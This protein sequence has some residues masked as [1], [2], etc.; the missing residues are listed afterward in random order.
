MYLVIYLLSETRF[1]RPGRLQNDCVA[2]GTFE[3]LSLLPPLKCWNY[4][5]VPPCPEHVLTLREFPALGRKVAGLGR[6]ER[7][8]HSGPCSA[9]ASLAP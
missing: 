5:H 4:R 6:T 3:L 7:R 1:C 9:Q 8:V 2:D